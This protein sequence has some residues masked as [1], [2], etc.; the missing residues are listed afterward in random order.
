MIPHWISVT[1]APSVPE[2]CEGGAARKG[3][4]LM[5]VRIAL[6]IAAGACRHFSV[7]N[8]GRDLGSSQDE[9]RESIRRH[10]ELR[11][12]RLQRDPVCRRHRWAVCAGNSHRRP[13]A[14]RALRKADT[15]GNVCVQRPCAQARSEQCRDRSAGFAQDERGLPL[16][17]CL[18]VRDPCQ[19]RQPVM[20]W[21]YGGAYTEGAGSSPH[22]DGEL[23]ARKGVVVVTF[24]YRLGPFGFFSHPE[25]TKES[26]R[27]RVRQSGARWTPSPRCVGCRPNIRCVRGRPNNVTIFGQSAGA[28]MIGG[29]GWFSRRQGPVPSRNRRERA[30]DGSRYGSHGAARASREGPPPLS[31]SFRTARR[32]KRT[33]ILRRPFLR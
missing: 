4:T 33:P 20:V 13:R 8:A 22:N 2:G 10:A 30:V 25:L 6:G 15:F 27:R 1:E 32:R 18:D 9:R 29:I 5:N 28:A 7:Q 11:R 14:G 21:I 3:T 24:N 26:G 16:P 23:L 17:E 31:A 12:A 19:A